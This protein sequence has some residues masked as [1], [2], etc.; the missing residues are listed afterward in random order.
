MCCQFASFSLVSFKKNTKV[1]VKFKAKVA[2]SSFFWTLASAYS[3][4][5]VSS[6]HFGTY[7]YSVDFKALRNLWHLTLASGMSDTQFHT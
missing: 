5:V 7:T 2:R 3:A 1:Y 4:S 6:L